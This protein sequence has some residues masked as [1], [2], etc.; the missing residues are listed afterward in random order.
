MNPTDIG[1]AIWASLVAFLASTLSGI[2]GFGGAMIF[3]PV[4]VALYGVRASVPIL[5][6]SVLL[7]NASRVYFNRRELDLKLVLLF[8][9]GA[10]P[11][12]VLGSF[13]YVALPVA[14]IQ[15]GIGAFLIFTVVLRHIHK[16]FKLTQAWVF[17][18]LGM[19]TGFLSALMG[20]VGPVSSPFFLAYG[21]TK[22]AFV[23]TEA[24][25]AVGMHVAKSITYNRLGVLNSREL[26]LG[27]GFGVVVS[28]GSYA[29]KKIL[30][31]ITREQFIWMVEVA[32]AAIGLYMLF[33]P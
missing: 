11:F 22:E 5:T 31:R 17:I 28:F 8:S 20:G 21:L 33:K 16:N 1:L 30:E 24:L 10:I 18:P 27:L 3:L 13:V 29:A 2:V 32:L 23:G 4:L 25:C 26:W 19:I 9:L 15:K 6:V 7:G 12:A 14:W